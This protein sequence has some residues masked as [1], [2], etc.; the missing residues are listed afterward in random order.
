MASIKS[1]HCDEEYGVFINAVLPGD[2]EGAEDANDDEEE[3][4]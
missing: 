2:P 3:E 4:E 1:Q